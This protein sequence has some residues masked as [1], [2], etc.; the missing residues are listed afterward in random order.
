M[1]SFLGKD[2]GGNKM[3][4]NLMKSKKMVGG[5]KQEIDSVKVENRSTSSVFKG[6]S[7]KRS[8]HVM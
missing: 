6:Q 2:V 8:M 3:E 4:E 7:Q 5:F 1:E